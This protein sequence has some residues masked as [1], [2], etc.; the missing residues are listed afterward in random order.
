MLTKFI[1]EKD[2]KEPWYRLSRVFIGTLKF[3]VSKT[4]R[5]ICMRPCIM[6]LLDTGDCIE[7]WESG[8]SH[9][10]LGAQLENMR[11][12]P[13]FKIQVVL[14]DPFFSMTKNDA[15][16]L[17]SRDFADFTSSLSP[18]LAAE[19]HITLSRVAAYFQLSN[20]RP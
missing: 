19:G 17:T 12:T 3:K 18:P 5:P 13:S 6:N 10:N 9:H 2:F 15:R 1:S 4:P 20:D 8:M 16:S 14:Y 7:I 11:L